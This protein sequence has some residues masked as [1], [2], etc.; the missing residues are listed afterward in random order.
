MPPYQPTEP[1][2]ETSSGAAPG[3]V[4]LALIEPSPH[5][6]A[7]TLD[8]AL[9]RVLRQQGP[10]ASLLDAENF[11]CG[12]SGREYRFPFPAEP[13][14]AL[15]LAARLDSAG[16][17]AF[18]VPPVPGLV[19]RLLAAARDPATYRSPWSVSFSSGRAVLS[20]TRDHSGSAEA[21]TVFGS[22]PPWQPTMAAAYRLDWEGSEVRVF[23]AAKPYGGLGRLASA[24]ESES[25]KAPFIGVARGGV[26]GGVGLKTRGPE[27]A[28]LLERLGLSAS[29][30][31]CSEIAAFGQVQE[32]RRR[33][34]DGIRF[35]SANLVYSSAPAKSFFDASMTLST[36][37]LNILLTAVTPRECAPF[38]RQ[39]GLGHLTIVDPAS[40]LSER[41]AA[42]RESH[43]GVVL[44]AGLGGEARGLET[45]ARGVDVI[46]AENRGSADLSLEPAQVQVEQ[47]A[48]RAFDSPLLVMRSY[49]ASL[50]VL[51]LR[52]EKGAGG[53]RW[54]A[55]ERHLRLDERFPEAP[56]FASFDP[57]DFGLGP[58]TA[59]ALVPSAAQI[60]PRTP[61]SVWPRITGHGFWSMAASLLAERTGS[62]AAL[63]RASPLGV[64]VE[65]E[66]TEATV[67][68]WLGTDEAVIVRLLGSQ[69]KP[70]LADAE[71]Q[72]KRAAKGL[73]PGGGVPLAA[74]GVGPGGTIHGAAPVDRELYRVAVSRRLLD[75]LNLNP[76]GESVPAGPVQDSVIAALKE[77]SGAPPAAFRDWMEGRPVYE[78]GLW[79]IHFRDI[80]LNIQSTRVI[81]DDAF[82]SVPN[83]R[84][85]G[86]DELLV[87]GVVK[88]DAEY[89]RSVYKWRSTA[90]VEY[91]RSAV[92]QRN[93]E[94]VV[95]ITANSVRLL[96]LG[97][98]RAGGIGAGW[99]AQSWGPSLGVQFD[100]QVE[101]V[102]GLRR[103]EVYSVFPG[104]EFYDGSWIKSLEV[105]GSLRRE[106]SRDPPDTQYGLRTRMIVR[107]DLGQAGGRPIT[108][109]GEAH[110]S[111]YFLT[112]HDSPQDLRAEGG[113]I[114]KLR[115]PVFKHLS[116]A[117]FLDFYWFGLKVRPL[118]G[119]SA[120]TGVSIG[121]S[122]LWKP[123]Y[124]RF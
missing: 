71:R 95:N 83:S 57:E 60:F 78:R 45:R 96:T 101:A 124:E 26:F 82:G 34:P 114:A 54:K 32:Y 70:L 9:E 48:R 22:E 17:T 8:A 44:L 51:E 113:V 77:R 102:P 49:G 107:R 110:A 88:A 94:K 67:R 97:T 121:F 6:L 59:P 7:T 10:A 100:G 120:V 23:L 62:E 92:T 87:G 99:L 105:S 4:R 61:D 75:S 15:A 85:Q 123:Q 112:N 106:V 36:G 93:R 11:P 2:P 18:I 111:Y 66:A 65:G 118:W 119:Y 73:S 27:L 41:M 56:G 72:A 24:L 16:E 40:A 64:E 55:A 58:S 35:I 29:G 86:Y 79:R 19:S 47:G 74:G 115:V 3:S 109:Q 39:A 81:R 14:Q 103:K 13:G 31:G 25:S 63:L 116:I 76:A 28:A 90:E 68:L 38:L 1:G 20:I 53:A 122:R 117:P 5:L 108:L 46:M 80:G 37:G 91:A 104:V 12:H 52:I 33:S 50:G 21:S 42:W 89:L 98:R 69:L 84:I 30:V 43:D